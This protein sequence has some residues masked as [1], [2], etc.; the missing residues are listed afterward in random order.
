MKIIIQKS[1]VKC[2]V[3]KCKNQ[4]HYSIVPEG[5][6]SS[7]YVNLCEEC[8]SDIYSALGKQLVPKS[9]QNM[10]ARAVKRGNE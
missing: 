3:G 7:Q 8:A 10:L 9:P 5:V 1:K 6:S 2:D 4:A